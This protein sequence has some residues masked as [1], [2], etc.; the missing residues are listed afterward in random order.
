[1][2]SKFT[3]SEEDAGTASTQEATQ[4][5]TEDLITTPLIEQCWKLYTNCR[6][7]KAIGVIQGPSGTGKSSALRAIMARHAQNELP[8]SIHRIKC[9]KACGPSSGVRAI[10]LDLGIGGAVTSTRSGAGLHYLLALAVKEIKRRKVAAL[11]LDDADYY[12]TDTIVGVVALF[13]QLIE[14]KCP[15]T[16]IMTG[17]LN[18]DR[19]I[20]QV[21]AAATRTLHVEHSEVMDIAMTAAV[22]KQ[23]GEPFEQLVESQR[24]DAVARAALRLIY[25]D[26]G[27]VFRRIR[28]FADLANAHGNRVLTLESVEA[29]LEQMQN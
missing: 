4:V 8:G 12:E 17:V 2:D 11:L 20:G 6:T 5:S 14:A 25:K 22:L 24:K 13:D 9:S 15:V 26:T 1:M 29:I 19:W 27:G 28:Y 21:P 3:L 10:L 18:E 7:A 23:M 16:F